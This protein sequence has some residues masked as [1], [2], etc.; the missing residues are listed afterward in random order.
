MV[1]VDQVQP[2]PRNPNR[3][4][5]DAVAESI[6]AIGFYGALIVHG[7]T[8]NIL[9]GSHRWVAAQTEGL[10]ELPALVYDV[11][12]DTAERIMV[13]DNEFARMARWDMAGLV[14]VLTDL[15]ASPAQLAAT[16]FDQSRFAELVAKMTP[17]PPDQ[18]PGFDDDLPTSYRCPSCGYE[19]AGQPR[20]G[21]EPT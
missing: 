4:D 5:A 6:D 20:P 10:A 2:H 12:E 3:G 13:G 21:G 11:D 7:P 14:S 16:G 17:A 9:A 8:G 15:S 18:F 19:W 1:A